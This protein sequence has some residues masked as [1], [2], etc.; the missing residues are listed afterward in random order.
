MILLDQKHPMMPPY[1]GRIWWYTWQ[2][3]NACP[4]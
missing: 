2:V 4:A 3:W 1:R